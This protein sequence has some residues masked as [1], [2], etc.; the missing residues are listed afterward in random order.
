MAILDSC[1]YNPPDGRFLMAAVKPFGWI[2][3]HGKR[4]AYEIEGKKHNLLTED[5]LRRLDAILSKFSTL[6]G[7]AAIGFLSYDLGRMYER[8]PNL[9]RNELHCPDVYLGLFASLI[10]H[11]YRTRTTWLTPTEDVQHDIARGVSLVDHKHNFSRPSR[12]A[13]SE[14][15]KFEP[16]AI[17]NF[18]I[19]GYVATVKKIK[20]YISAGD[21]FQANLTQRFR[22]AL[23]NLRPAEVFL[24]LRTTC[25]MPFSAFLRFPGLSVVSASP[26]MFLR[27]NRGLVEASLIKGTRPRGRNST[28]DAI[29]QRELEESEKDRAENVMIV[30]LMRNDLGKVARFGSVE[31]KEMCKVRTFPAVMHSVS[32]LTAQLR[33][34]MT[35]MD[36]LRSAFPSGSITGAPKIRAMQIIEEL[37]PT[38]RGV[39]MGSIG[40]FGFDG[41]MEISVAIRTMSIVDDFAYFNVGGGIVADSK[42][43]EEYHE[44]LLKARPL[45]AALDAC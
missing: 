10:I 45:L 11:D 15:S 35:R 39:S 9:A 24:R 40:Y 7:G 18:T 37:E 41:S 19:E 26:E 17:T 42:P 38:R 22:V 6:R 3:T 33:R 13:E 16:R 25:P 23:G 34:G 27:L 12:W 4:V 29:L 44:S 43:T 2:R 36:L 32:R 14:S 21:I 5:P 1:E 28:Q 8:I 30:D 31:V 20:E